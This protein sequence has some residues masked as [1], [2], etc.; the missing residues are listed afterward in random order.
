[1]TE[2]CEERLD[3]E[4]KTWI[5]TYADETRGKVLRAVQASG[6]PLFVF[7]SRGE[8]WAWLES[9]EAQ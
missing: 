7:P 1:M 8:A 6:V 4:F 5:E 2:G 3:D 9:F